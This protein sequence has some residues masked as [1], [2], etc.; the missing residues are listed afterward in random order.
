MVE[1]KAPQCRPPV[2][3][4]PAATKAA[5]A[6]SSPAHARFVGAKRRLCNSNFWG[7]VISKFNG[8]FRLKD[9]PI[10]HVFQPNT[11][12]K[13]D[14]PPRP[15]RPENKHYLRARPM[16]AA[17]IDSPT[18]ELNSH[19]D[20]SEQGHHCPQCVVCSATCFFQDHVSLGRHMYHVCAFP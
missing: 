7:H 3:R 11:E 2:W 9:D 14:I 17:L 19:I 4:S 6:C 12:M 20:N 1:T 15:C 5:S 16:H 18:D 10:P 8:I 13:W